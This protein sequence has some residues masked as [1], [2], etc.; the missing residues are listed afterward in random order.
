MVKYFH[1]WVKYPLTQCSATKMSVPTETVA[2]TP[3]PPFNLPW[4]RLASRPLTPP[5]PQ[6]ES[7]FYCHSQR[8]PPPTH[9]HYIYTYIHSYYPKG[10]PKYGEKKSIHFSNL[11]LS[12]LLLSIKSHSI[13]KTPSITSSSYLGRKNTFETRLNRSCH[14]KAVQITTII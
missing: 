1:F 7:V 13:H 9:T 5:T 3:I 8:G 12:S 10:W 11:H 4:R 2:T 14:H 6:G